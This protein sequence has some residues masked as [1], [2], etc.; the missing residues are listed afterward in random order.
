MTDYAAAMLFINAF[1]WA[2]ESSKGRRYHY[3]L[4]AAFNL[5][6]SLLCLAWGWR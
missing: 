1:F 6:M 2:A 4:M 3:L 5:F